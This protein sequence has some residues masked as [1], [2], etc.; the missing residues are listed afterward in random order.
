MQDKFR[1]WFLMVV[2]QKGCLFLE[3]ASE[4]EGGRAFVGAMRYNSRGR[5]NEDVEK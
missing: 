2:P 4:N 1:F 5:M 3:G